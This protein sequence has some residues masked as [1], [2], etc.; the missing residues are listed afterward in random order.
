M[1]EAQPFKSILAAHHALH[2]V[3]NGFADTV[4]GNLSDNEI[5]TVAERDVASVGHYKINP[6]KRWFREPLDGQIAAGILIEFIFAYSSI[7]LS[8]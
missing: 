7:P 6:F 1:L 2:N 5:E 4:I 3:G 8:V